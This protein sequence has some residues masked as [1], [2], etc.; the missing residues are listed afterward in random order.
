MEPCRGRVWLKSLLFSGGPLAHARVSSG[1][2]ARRPGAPPADCQWVRAGGRT[3][4]SPRG[5]RHCWDSSPTSGTCGQPLLTV[6]PV[7]PPPVRAV[8]AA[9]ARAPATAPWAASSASSGPLRADRRPRMATAARRHHRWSC[10]LSQPPRVRRRSWWT[11]CRR[12]P[13]AARRSRPRRSVPAAG[14][15][16]PLRRLPPLPV[17]S[18]PRR[19]RLRGPS[20]SRDLHAWSVRWPFFGRSCSE[21]GARSL[22]SARWLLV[23]PNRRPRRTPRRPRRPSAL[24][25]SGAG[26]RRWRRHRRSRG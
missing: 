19:Q 23:P 1:C 24:P 12:P 14:M 9:T 20:R 15:R 17:A 7:S 6:A 2:S 22:N 13:T 21:L 25:R 8:G 16:P 18:G 3:Q 26:S 5:R 4:R 11:S 10:P